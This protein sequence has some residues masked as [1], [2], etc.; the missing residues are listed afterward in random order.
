MEYWGMAFEERE[1]TQVVIQQ[2]HVVSI[3]PGTWYLFC[4]GGAGTYEVSV[5]WGQDQI[6]QA[7]SEMGSDLREGG[8]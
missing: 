4:L 8:R 3:L 6:A 1:L 5:A 7:L 2:I